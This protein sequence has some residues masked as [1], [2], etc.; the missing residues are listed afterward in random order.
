MFKWV[1]PS[2]AVC[3]EADWPERFTSTEVLLAVDWIQQGNTAFVTDDDTARQVLTVIGLTKM[4][5]ADR[6]HFANTGTIL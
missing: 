2:L 1:T 6:L 5:V 4:E 3:D